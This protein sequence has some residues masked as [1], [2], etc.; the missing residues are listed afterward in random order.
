MLPLKKL[1]FFKNIAHS[2]TPLRLS[3]HAERLFLFKK[4]YTLQPKHTQKA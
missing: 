2:T 3:A 1:T 4:D